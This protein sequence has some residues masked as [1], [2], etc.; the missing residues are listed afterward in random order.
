MENVAKNYRRGFTLVELVV[1]I[2]ILGILAGI[3]I[4]RYMEMQEEARGAKLLTDLRSIESA[5]NMYAAKNGSYPSK[6]DPWK[7]TTADYKEAFGSTAALVPNYLTSWPQPPVGNLRFT[8]RDGKVYRYILSGSKKDDNPYSWFG[9]G[10]RDNTNTYGYLINR[11]VIAHMCV[12]DF[13]NGK[14]G[15]SVW[16]TRLPSN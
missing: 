12:D 7:A 11:A 15:N 8:G 4:P 2:A 9:N 13:L 16:I 5:A 10:D 6:I 1:V 14:E 3:A